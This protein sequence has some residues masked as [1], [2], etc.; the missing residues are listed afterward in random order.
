MNE[1]RKIMSFLIIILENAYHFRDRNIN[2]KF[3]HFFFI[4]HR[5][6]AYLVK[7]FWLSFKRLS[8]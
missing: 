6:P 3:F 5:V 8:V 1:I 7:K 2:Y 4:E